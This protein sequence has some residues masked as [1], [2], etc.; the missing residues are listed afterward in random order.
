MSGKY[1]DRE[2]GEPPGT[3]VPPPGVNLGRVWV[4][5]AAEVWRREPGFGERFAARVLRSP[6]LAR[7]LLA[8]PS[9][10]VPWLFATTVMLGAGAVVT[11]TTGQPVVALVAP[12]VAA[13]GVAYAYG[14]ATDPAWELAQ[15]MAVS[16]RMVLLVRVLAV[17]ATDAVLGL[18]A[19]LASY[20]A[21]G[22]TVNWLIPMT[23]V[24]TLALAAATLTQSSDAGATI[25][26]SGWAITVLADRTVTGRVA[27][28]VD[29]TRLDLPYLV[30]AAFCIIAVFATAGV[31]AP[32]PRVW[33]VKS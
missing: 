26:L 19:S 3:T 31:S 10:L 24:S 5:V 32:T 30:F 9:L 20:H 17:F 21:V 12:A 6:G 11:L 33:K 14:P 16:D 28:A 4:G 13:A 1:Q 23:A 18:A 25:G 8:T 29:D 27:A 2:A 22:I 15:T 7:A